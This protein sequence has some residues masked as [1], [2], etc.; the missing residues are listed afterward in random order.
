M[1][2]WKM[3]A[4]LR[5]RAPQPHI[6]HEDN[7][8]FSMSVGYILQLPSIN[9]LIQETF[10]SLVVCMFKV[11]KKLRSIMCLWGDTSNINLKIIYAG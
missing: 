5:L 6:P 8:M 4:L 9:L 10:I 1:L 11:R 2:S 3:I 7:F